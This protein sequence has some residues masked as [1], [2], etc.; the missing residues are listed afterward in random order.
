MSFLASGSEVLVASRK[1]AIR[2]EIYSTM[3][4]CVEDAAIVALG[5]LK[6]VVELGLVAAM[7]LAR[8]ICT[9]RNIRV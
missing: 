5:A 2:E 7:R 3:A 8:P 9:V 1:S 4:G 6:G